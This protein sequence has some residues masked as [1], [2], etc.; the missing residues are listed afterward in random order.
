MLT[1]F[2]SLTINWNINYTFE[3]SHGAGAKSVTV[4]PTGCDFDPIRG[5]EIFT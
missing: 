2:Y 5:D 1:K 4:K 3:A